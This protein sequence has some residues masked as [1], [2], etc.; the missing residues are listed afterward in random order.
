MLTNT[1]SKTEEK[2]QIFD[3]EHTDIF[4]WGTSVLP[5]I[6]LVQNKLGQL[7]LFVFQSLIRSM[8][9]ISKNVD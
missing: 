7:S 8:F 4:N 3:K 1:N 9:L 6:S 2:G 5:L